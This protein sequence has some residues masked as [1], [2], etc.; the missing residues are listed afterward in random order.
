M[1]RRN[2][3][4][5][6]RDDDDDDDNSKTNDPKVFKLGTGITLG[7][8]RSGTSP[9]SWDRTSAFYRCR[10]CR[11]RAAVERKRARRLSD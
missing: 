10:C 2:G 6:L 11:R 4:S 1:G 8:P 9:Q 3:P 5:G 7:Y